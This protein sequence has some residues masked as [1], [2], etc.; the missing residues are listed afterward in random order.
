M[1]WYILICISMCWYIFIHIG[2]CWYVLVCIDTYWY[3]LVHVGM[4]WYILVC[5]VNISMCWYLLV[6]IFTCWYMLVHI[7]M[8]WYIL[9]H[10]GS[11]GT[12]WYMLVR[13]EGEHWLTSDLVSVNSDCRS[14]FSWFWYSDFFLSYCRPVHTQWIKTIGCKFTHQ[15]CSLQYSLKDGYGKQPVFHFINIHANIWIVEIICKSTAQ[16][17]ILNAEISVFVQLLTKEKIGQ[18]ISLWMVINMYLFHFK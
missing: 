3:V 14:D 13:V 10:F 7:G 1:C 16:F 15:Y 11:V 9:I 4:C 17:L 5:V 6:H 8:C 2:I 18:S 12:C